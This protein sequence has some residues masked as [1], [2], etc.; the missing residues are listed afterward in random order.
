[1][2][3]ATGTGAHP[4][5]DAAVA[6]KNIGYKLHAYKRTDAGKG[7]KANLRMK[8]VLALKEAQGNRCAACN[9]EL[10]WCYTPK[11]TRQFSVDRLD[12]AK[13]HTR[14]NVRLTCL[15]CNLKWGAAAL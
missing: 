1:M 11:D 8:D 4:T 15:D 13:G 10:L 6:C 7:F 5:F 14:D 2:L 12:N 9:L 3:P